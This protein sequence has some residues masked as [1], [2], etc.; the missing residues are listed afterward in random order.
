[1]GFDT[2]QP[3]FNVALFSFFAFL[4]LALATIGIYSMLSYSVA[5]RTQEIGIR[6]ALGALRGNVI[7][8]MLG[9]A[10]GWWRLARALVWQGAW[11]WT[12]F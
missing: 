8:W 12:G 4:G 11:R 6:M 9:E 3:Q 10:G 2:K 1:M 5:R 7:R